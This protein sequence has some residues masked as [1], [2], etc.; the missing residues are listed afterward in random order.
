MKDSES[1]QNSLS[2]VRNMP[3]LRLQALEKLRQAIVEGT[4]APGSRLVER[5]LCVML[6]VSRTVVREILRQLEAEGWVINRP[7]KGPMVA[8]ISLEEA[9]QMYEIRIALEGLAAKLCAIRA[10]DEQIKRLEKVVE[11][12]AV[13]ARKSDIERQIKTIEQF[14][15]VLLEGA[16]NALMSSYLASQRSRLARLRSLSLSQPER[17]AVSVDEK[18]R[19]VAAIQ[20]RDPALA[21][22]YSEA[23]VEAAAAAAF[24]Q[25]P[26]AAPRPA[27]K[28]ENRKTSSSPARSRSRRQPAKVPANGR[29]HRA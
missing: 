13:A 21:Q 23:H 12:M 27:E 14:Y 29:S 19:I 18:A 26:P 9:R 16:G 3:T 2:V 5:K 24:E 8:T 4:F 28:R 25:A 22:K 11:V 1:V 20:A 6:D 15:E 17:A 10:T 7:Y